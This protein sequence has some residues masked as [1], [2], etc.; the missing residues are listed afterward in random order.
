MLKKAKVKVS[1]AWVLAKK[2]FV[3]LCVWGLVFSVVTIGQF[4]V[5]F[6]YDDTLVFSSPAYEK[7]FR[8]GA[9]QF[10]TR[11]WEVVN[12]SYDL[13]RRKVVPNALAWTF[14][15]L[16]FKVSILTARPE[17]GAEGLRKEWRRLAT[18][19]V[20]GR[21]PAP[22]PKHEYLASGNYVAFFGD[23][24]S[25][26]QAARRAKVAAVRIAR[27]PKSQYKDDYHPGS[28]GEWVIPFSEY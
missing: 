9:P 21:Y 12:S 8:S 6:D 19:F 24:D 2:V 27:S 18:D 13:E 15:L 5:A 11:F 1:Q 16:G 25:D 4:R 17:H 7:A 3:G 28:L 14:R 23:S 10:S 26:L 20:F 22:S